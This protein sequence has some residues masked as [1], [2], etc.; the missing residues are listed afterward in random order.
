MVIVLVPEGVL[1]EPLA[2]PLVTVV[3]LTLTVD[4][5][6]DKVL[7]TVGVTVIEVPVTVRL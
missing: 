6:P 3:P 5:E 1:M 4:A 7:A 2:L